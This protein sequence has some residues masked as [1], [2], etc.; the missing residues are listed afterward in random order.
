MRRMRALLLP[1]NSV[2]ERATDVKRDRHAMSSLAKFLRSPSFKFVLI[3]CLVF[4]ISIPLALVWFML[5]ERQ[6][7]AGAVQ[8]EIAND[9]GRGQRITGPYLIVPYTAKA[10]VIDAGKPV[11]LERERFAIVLPDSFNASADASTEIRK[12]SIYDV[13]VYRSAITLEGRFPDVNIGLMDA[14]AVSARWKDAFLALGI[15]DVS[16]LK[17]NVELEADG[18]KPIPFEPSIGIEA[19]NYPGIH[20]RVLAGS[21]QASTSLK[22]SSPMSYK[23]RLALNGSSFLRFA[24]VGRDSSVLIKS[25]WPHPSFVGFLPASRTIANNGFTAEWRIPHLA[26]SVPEAWSEGTQN[27]IL[28]RFANADLGVNLYVPVDFYSLVERSLKYGFMFIATVFGGVF[29]MELLSKTRVHPIQYIFVGFAVVIFFVLLLGARGAFWLHASLSRSLGHHER[30]DLPLRWQGLR[31]PVPRPHDRR[32]SCRSLWPS[33]FYL[34][35]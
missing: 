2:L 23:I 5:S 17:D 1:R 20:A 19:I 27:V 22:S 12:R 7:R 25:D 18:G 24:P 31:Q 15:S 13:T 4:A 29:V 11:E 33:L 16:G 3:G 32:H 8:S 6:S 10:T 14:N 21:E 34:A 35:A 30:H 26:R 9:W 28:D